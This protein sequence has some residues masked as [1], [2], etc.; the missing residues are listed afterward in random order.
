MLKPHWTVIKKLRIGVNFKSVSK[1]VEDENKI[2]ADDEQH[3]EEEQI[4][5]ENSELNPEIQL[6]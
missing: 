1:S 2:S 6:L 3:D 4:A 5:N